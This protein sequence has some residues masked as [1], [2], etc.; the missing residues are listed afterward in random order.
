V[1]KL[2]QK[3]ETFK[4]PLPGLHVASKHMVLKNMKV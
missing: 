2:L 1:L 4:L 3:N